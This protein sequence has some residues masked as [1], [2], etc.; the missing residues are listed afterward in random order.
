MQGNFI[1]RMV[2]YA[3]QLLLEH[4]IEIPNIYLNSEIEQKYQFVE[5]ISE[6][7]GLGLRQVA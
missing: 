6:H 4:N 2:G 1:G 5:K 7:L 3:V